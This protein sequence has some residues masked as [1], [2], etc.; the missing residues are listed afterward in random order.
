[1]FVNDSFVQSFS[2]SRWSS[3]AFGLIGW[4]EK[5]S[6]GARCNFPT[7]WVWT[8]GPDAATPA[9]AINRVIRANKQNTVFYS[10]PQLFDGAP[11][12]NFVVIARVE[13]GSG[14]T[15]DYCGVQYRTALDSA[16]SDLSAYYLAIV[17]RD[18]RAELQERSAGNWQVI[19]QVKSNE[20]DGDQGAVNEIMLIVNG[21][22]TTMIVNGQAVATRVDDTLLN[23]TLG[24]AAGMG[25]QGTQMA[26]TFRNVW[27]WKLN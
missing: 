13:F 21:N 22:T 9:L 4:T 5:S 16:N 17:S 23:G 26:C 6:T 7:T 19:E 25:N 14:V 3:G 18:Q 11:F 2:N 1:V 20:I 24:L 27:V 10:N 12:T 15:T 8:L